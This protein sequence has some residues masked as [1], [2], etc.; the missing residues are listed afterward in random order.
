MSGRL[1]ACR[2]PSVTAQRIVPNCPAS[3][4]RQ[5]QTP[6]V[7]SSRPV[8]ATLGTVYALC[9]AR[10][11]GITARDIEGI[12][13][14]NLRVPRSEFAAVWLEAERLNEEN[15]CLGR[16][17]WYVTGVVVTCRW[18]ACST[19]VFIYPHGPKRQVAT[20]PITGTQHLAHEELIEAETL[21][22]E[23]RAMRYP[24][25]VEDRPQWY[26][27][28]IKTLH[29]AWRGTAGPP[30]SVSRAETG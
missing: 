11:M 23:V 4:E 8:T 5:R 20:A 3:S 6:E 24:H 14:G 12:P 15:N 26:E 18:L 25:L 29:W 7:G 2:R 1:F 21:A 19:T 16:G 9:D 17:D 13:R 30:L 10:P 28:V 22:A 27:A